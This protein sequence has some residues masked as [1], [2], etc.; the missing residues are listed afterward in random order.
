[1]DNANNEEKLEKLLQEN[2]RLTE[3]IHK[4]SKRVNRYV[5]IQNILSFVYFLL[6]VVPLILGAIFLPPLIS[7]LI[8]PYMELLDSGKDATKAL[9][10]ANSAG[11]MDIMDQAQKIINE[12]KK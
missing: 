5:T 11:V 9:N 8:N 12:N 4:M 2:L 6:I 1:M 10:G 3:E 7:N